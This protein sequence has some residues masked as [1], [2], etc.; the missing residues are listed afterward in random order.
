MISLPGMLLIGAAGRNVG[1]TELACA[2]IRRFSGQSPITGV[3]VTVIAESGGRCPRGGAGCGVCSS[4]QGPFCLTRETGTPAAKDTSRMLAA[5]ARDVFWLR[6]LKEHLAAGLDALLE[7]LG[8]DSVC[9]CE[10]NSLRLVVHPGV[11]L[12][13]RD[14]GADAFKPTAAAV[15][16]YA[17]RM[18]LFDG[19][20]LDFGP[21]DLELV[22][23]QWQL[24]PRPPAARPQ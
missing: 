12:M 16:R 24:V 14:A 11:F 5:G 19:V 13:A 10:S 6:V 3:K 8:R 7:R 21:A 2:I 22:D 9:V 23:R 15:R 18:V 1:K 17:D 4:L 20:R